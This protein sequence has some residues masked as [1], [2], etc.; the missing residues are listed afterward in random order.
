M[1]I[2]PQFITSFDGTRL[3]VYEFGKQDGPVIFLVNGLGGNILTWAHL[4]N[5][6][7]HRFRFIS[8]DYRGIFESG[9]PP[10]KDFSMDAHA[11]DAMAVLDH[12]QVEKA[13]WIGW[14]MGVQL[15]LELMRRMPEG[16]LALVLLNGAYA[17]PL[18]RGRP[19][20]KWAALLAMDL[21]ALYGP[22]LKVYA[23]P[24]LVSRL[25]VKL[26]KW[27]GLVSTNLDETVFLRLARKFAD[28]DFANFR[29][30]FN[31]MVQHD[32]ESVLDSISIPVLVVTGTR[33]RITPSFLS[34]EIVQ[35]LSQAEL[36]EVEDASHYALVEYPD[37]IILRIQRFLD[38]LSN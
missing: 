30:I 16:A 2:S 14:S 6:F 28:V 36:L 32:A 21:V 20:L 33:D 19:R 29:D 37:L 15:V 17:R 26:A 3:A 11:R 5:H 35:R 22:V 34:R 12:F 10:D 7:Q 4:L 38:A 24:W 31:G 13:V 27:V 23:R 25:P 8:F 1:R 9:T 18:D